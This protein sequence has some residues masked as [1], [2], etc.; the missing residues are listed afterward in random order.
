MVRKAPS[1][2]HRTLTCDPPKS[3]A[4]KRK[5]NFLTLISAAGISIAGHSLRKAEKS[6]AM[7][8]AEHGINDSAL[9]YVER[10]HRRL[11]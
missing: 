11:C 3:L 9:R 5:D 6:P 2:V 4:Y 1:D 8:R 7:M 10:P